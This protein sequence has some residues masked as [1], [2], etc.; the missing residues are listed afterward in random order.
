MAAANHSAIMI[1]GAPSTIVLNTH[2]LDGG[3]PRRPPPLLF[4]LCVLHDI[5]TV[6]MF[7]RLLAKVVD[8]GAGDALSPVSRL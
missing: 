4:T 6:T 1:T 7:W 8:E 3:C 5:T 2:Q